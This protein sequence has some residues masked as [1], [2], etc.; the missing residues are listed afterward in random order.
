MAGRRLTEFFKIYIF[1]I[2]LIMLVGLAIFGVS[3]AGA[4]SCTVRATN[5]LGGETAV[6]NMFGTTDSHAELATSTN[7]TQIVCCSGITGLGTNCSGTYATVLRLSSTTNAHVQQNTYSNYANP[8]CLSVPAGDT[9]GVVYGASCTGSTTV[10]SMSSTTN[11]HIGDLNA[12]ATKICATATEPVVISVSVS[13]GVVTYGAVA[14][15]SS[16]S[17]ITNGQTQTVTNNGSAAETFNIKGQN[18]PCPWTLAGSAG[19]E[20]YEHE[21][22]TNTG[23]LWTPL[24]TNYQTLA[25]GIA[26][27]SSTS[28]DLR[29]TV[30][31]LT[32]C[33][34]SQAVDV[35]VQ[36]T[37]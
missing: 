16:S 28:L 2:A 10:A 1:D 17:T 24:T 22:S 26:A 9:V 36:A 11:A 14:F 30:P 25:T 29:V 5:C 32:A 13:S 35:T 18:A 19:S 23:A 27:S 21:F 7:Y 15:G 3:Q 20:Q 6:L 8:V 37:Q 4:L 12:Y 34:T 31:T 33:N